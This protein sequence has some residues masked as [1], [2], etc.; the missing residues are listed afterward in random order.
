MQSDFL[1]GKKNPLENSTEVAETYKQVAHGIVR[2]DT[3]RCSL[4]N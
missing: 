2:T 1:L 4:D 3:E